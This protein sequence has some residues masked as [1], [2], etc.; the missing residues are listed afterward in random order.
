MADKRI[1]GPVREVKSRHAS[2][3]NIKYK[4]TELKNKVCGNSERDG[5]N[6]GCRG[7][8]KVNSEVRF[9]LGPQR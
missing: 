4:S 2:K 3:C 5:F 8:G 9:Q 6:G 1:Y 7:F